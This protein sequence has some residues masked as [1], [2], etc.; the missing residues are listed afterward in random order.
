VYTGYHEA[1]LQLLT[2]VL[3]ELLVVRLTPCGMEG[4][5]NIVV[6]NVG[7]TRY[8]TTVATLLSQVSSFFNCLLSDDWAEAGQKELFLDRDGK[9]FK[10]ILR[11]LRASLD[12][13]RQLVQT[14]SESER[15]LVAEE[16]KFFQ[17]NNLS[18]LLHTEQL[19]TRQSSKTEQVATHD[20]KFFDRLRVDFL[21]SK[22]VDNTVAIQNEL[23]A[24]SAEA[25]QI[26][27]GSSF[28]EGNM[29]CAV[30]AKER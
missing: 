24:L 16:A 4:T 9:L 13:Q 5:Q 19:A 3:Q 1:L 12:G 11:F 14:F 21:N 28:H 18:N 2:P 25:W 30:L 27:V 7:G 20:F 6:M 17:L 29:F 23:S 10:H 8:T 26:I 15:I 22:R